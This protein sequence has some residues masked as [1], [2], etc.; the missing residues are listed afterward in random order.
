MEVA[1]KYVSLNMLIDKDNVPD[2]FYISII[3]AD[4]EDTYIKQKSIE[5]IKIIISNNWYGLSKFKDAHT[6]LVV[7]FCGR[8]L[9]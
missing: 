7:L 9:V 5:N 6:Y 1:T 8:Y 4:S 2:I 3:F